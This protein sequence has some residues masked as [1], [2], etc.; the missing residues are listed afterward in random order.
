MWFPGP[1]LAG[2]WSFQQASL[3]SSNSPICSD[4]PLR[5]TQSS[6]EGGG[7][8]QEGGLTRDFPSNL[9]PVL[10]LKAIYVPPP[11]K[12]KGKP[13]LEVIYL[14]IAHY[15]QLTSIRASESLRV[16][17]K[18]KCSTLN[19]APSLF[20]WPWKNGNVVGKQELIAIH[21]LEFFLLFQ[22]CWV[23]I[24][25]AHTAHTDSLIWMVPNQHSDKFI[26]KVDWLSLQ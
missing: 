13:H 17:Y 14:V 25:L 20:H 12:K 4:L 22:S 6:I 1:P 7:P 24:G 15:L 10:C 23:L 18:F 5:F 3:C 8:I 19:Q 26:V 21:D 16:L 9:K 2:S 11:L